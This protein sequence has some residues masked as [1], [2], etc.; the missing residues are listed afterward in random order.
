M[1]ESFIT[2]QAIRQF[3]R[4]GETEAGLLEFLAAAHEKL[5]APYRVGALLLV[6]EREQ[7]IKEIAK[8][9][10]T[11]GVPLFVTVK[12]MLDLYE[13]EHWTLHPIVLALELGLP[14]HEDCQLDAGEAADIRQI[15]EQ[16]DSEPDKCGDPECEGCNPVPEVIH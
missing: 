13:A 16:L 10:K 1:K 9:S 15:I 12:A 3:I 8:I 7:P 11:A 14:K 5:F 2:N 6:I 4:G